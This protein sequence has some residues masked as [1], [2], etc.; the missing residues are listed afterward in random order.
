MSEFVAL[1]DDRYDERERQ[2]VRIGKEGIARG[3]DAKLNDYFAE[4]YTF[5]G[6]DGSMTFEQVKG[7]F[8]SM[9]AALTDFKCERREVIREGSLIAAQTSMSGVFAHPFQSALV[10]PVP[11]TGQ[12]VHFELMNFFRYTSDGKLVQE[13]VEYDNVSFLR[14]LGVDLVAAYK[15]QQR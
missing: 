6:P 3:D 12:P 1:D 8:A 11:P 15:A 10:G 9:R 5:S 14:Q 2:L 13:W 7:F 4:G